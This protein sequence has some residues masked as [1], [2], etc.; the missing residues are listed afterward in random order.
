[1]CVKLREIIKGFTTCRCDGI[2]SLYWIRS[3]VVQM[4]KFHIVNSVTYAIQFRSVIFLIYRLCRQRNL[5]RTQSGNWEVNGL[6]FILKLK[7]L[8]EKCFYIFVTG[9]VPEEKFP[10]MVWFHPGDFHWGAPIYWDASVLTARHKVR[11]GKIIGRD[12]QTTW[13]VF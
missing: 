10:V 11:I 9:T 7:K 3:D 1:M 2:F 6:L 12:H 5:N 4:R 8:F 13:R